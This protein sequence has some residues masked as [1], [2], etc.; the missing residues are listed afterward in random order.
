MGA[1]VPKILLKSRK[2]ATICVCST[3][4]HLDEGVATPHLAV[5]KPDVLAPIVLAKPSFCH[6]EETRHHAPVV[7]LL[8]TYRHM[9]RHWVVRLFA[10]DVMHPNQP[11]V[12]HIVQ[13][14]LTS[15]KHGKCHKADN[16]DS[17]GCS[18][19]VP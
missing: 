11:S 4:V 17:P 2:G 1:R 12:F 13:G 10:K 15:W 18:M 14:G 3:T 5:I 7:Q 16:L 19:P 9:P 6:R 8:M